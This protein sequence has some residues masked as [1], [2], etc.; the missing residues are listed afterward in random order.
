M[1]IILVRNWW[2]LALRGLVAI[3]F[4]LF[5]LLR[6]GLALATLVLLFGA[7]ALF[8]GIFAIVAGVRAAERH[9]RWGPMAIEGVAGIVAAA[10]A[11]FSPALTVL[12]LLYLVSVWA[13][14]TGALRIVAAIRLRRHVEGEWVLLVNG[15]LSVLFALLVVLR[16]ALALVT[17]A[18]LI[19]GYALLFGVMALGLALHLRR[20]LHAVAGASPLAA[21]R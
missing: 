8:D 15:V 9:E 19:G 11:F 18:W 16:P 20:G 13:A 14:F 21:G 12:A 17:L 4:G 10:I 2:A 6:P 1:T 3:L 5:A 7:Y